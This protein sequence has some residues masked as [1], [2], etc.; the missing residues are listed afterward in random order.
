MNADRSKEVLL[1]HS[2]AILDTL[3]QYARARESFHSKCGMLLVEI[4]PFA[5]PV[6]ASHPFRHSVLY[7]IVAFLYKRGD[8][9][10]E[11]KFFSVTSRDNSGISI[12]D[13]I[14]SVLINFS[15]MVPFWQEQRL[16]S[17]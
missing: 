5:K 15:R 3:V 10:P 4:F 2:K 8:E 16:R 13:E 6:D 7:K 17:I 1:M 11:R 9:V 14:P 12:A